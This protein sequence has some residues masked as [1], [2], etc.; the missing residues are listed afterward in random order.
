MF[1][2]HPHDAGNGQGKEIKCELS[3]SR[4]TSRRSLPRDGDQF[5]DSY[6]QSSKFR[7]AS[8]DLSNGLPSPDGCFQF[9]VLNSVHGDGGKD[10]IEVNARIIIS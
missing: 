4:R 3:Y 1:H 8:T 2:I 7:V 5:M 9:V 6:Y 10:P